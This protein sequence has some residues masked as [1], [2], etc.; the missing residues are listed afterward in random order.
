MWIQSLRVE[1]YKRFR[2]TGTITFS[3]GMN[4][5]VG[6]NDA[7]KTALMEAL[8]STARINNPHK[9]VATLP[10]QASVPRGQTRI[11]RS[12]R[13]EGDEIREVLAGLVRVQIGTVQG[14]EQWAI[15]Q[16]NEAKR[17]GGTL[18]VEEKLQVETSMRLASMHP[19]PQLTVIAANL[20]HPND[21]NGVLAG[22]GNQ[23][24]YAGA[25]WSYV[26]PRIYEFRTQR[27]N[28]AIGNTGTS[29]ELASDAT[30][31]AEV[32]NNL[33][34][35]NFYR[36]RELLDRVREVF[37]HITHVSVRQI[38]QSR[39]RIDVWDTDPTL[40]RDDLAIAL[41][42]SGTGIGQVLAM[43]YVVVTARFPRIILIDEPHSFLH[44]GAIRKLFE[45]FGRY[46]QHQYIITTHSPTALGTAAAQR[47]YI[48]RRE[49]EQSVV[50]EIDMRNSADLTAF[51]TEVGARLSDVYGPDRILWCE[52]KTEELCFP[53]IMRSV[54]PASLIGV[55]VLAVAHTADLDGRHAEKIVGMYHRLSAGASLMPPAVAFVLDRE[56]RDANTLKRLQEAGR[57]LVH[58]LPRRMYE[59][60]LLDSEAIVTVLNRDDEG[61]ACDHSSNSVD[62]WMA[63]NGARFSPKGIAVSDATFAEKVDGANLLASLFSELT[64]TRARYDK[65][66]HGPLMTEL[67]LERGSREL[68]DLGEW[69][70]E[71]QPTV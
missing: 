6:Q 17:S 38:D 57:G 64:E 51:L 30:N 68:T 50:S 21:F 32:L 45:I 33:Q 39:L 16:L 58:F 11:T 53:M 36:Y 12:V 40:G 66:K 1:D 65:T 5:I 19:N 23:P 61:R 43:L 25:L 28:F 4:I 7:G 26:S 52:G 69:L 42:E 18:I 70:T 8:G 41:S 37:P 44:P 63:A 2:D 13:M 47:M 34:A 24:D 27:Y 14:N 60:F 15:D 56:N 9:S 22:L 59:N 48:V 10:S 62:E 71:L 31:L 46:A 29:F 55:E 3:P 35:S 49:P 20:L 54:S 67:L